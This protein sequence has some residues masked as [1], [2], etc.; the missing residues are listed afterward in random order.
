MNPVSKALRSYDYR[1][2]VES[3]M[4]LGADEI[5]R[6]SVHAS[7]LEDELEIAKSVIKNL[8]SAIDN[9]HETLSLLGAKDD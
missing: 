6:L 2:S 4:R 8:T 9:L 3:V 5:D 7:R 1:S